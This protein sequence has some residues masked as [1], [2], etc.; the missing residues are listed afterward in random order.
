MDRHHFNDCAAGAE[1]THNQ[2]I[3][4]FSHMMGLVLSCKT[5][6]DWVYWYKTKGLSSN[7]KKKKTYS[8]KISYLTSTPVF[9]VCPSASD[10]DL[11]IGWKCRTKNSRVSGSKAER[12]D[13][14][15]KAADVVFHCAFREV[16][17]VKES[18]SAAGISP[19]ATACLRSIKCK[20]KQLICLTGPDKGTVRGH[21]S[22]GA[23]SKVWLEPKQETSWSISSGN[24]LSD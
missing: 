1:A 3:N 20:G 15:I 12:D 4:Q 7:E 11:Y 18:P 22:W 14:L 13:V 5:S 19:Q 2:R 23:K 24:R 9:T 16:A 8:H 6:R 10:E 17:A 21:G